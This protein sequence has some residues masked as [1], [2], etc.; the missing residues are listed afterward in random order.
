MRFSLILWFIL[1]I[2]WTPLHAEDVDVEHLAKPE[3]VDLAGCMWDSLAVVEKYRLDGK[4]FALWDIFDAACAAEMENVKSAAARQLKEEI[5]KQLLPDQLVLEMTKNA[6]E[7]YS[8]RPLSACKGTGCV[9]NTYRACLIGQMSIALKDRKSPIDFEKRSQQHCEDAENVARSALS[10]DFNEVQQRHIAGGLN[11]K[12]ND[13]IRNMLVGIRQQV[14]VLYGEDLTQTQP[15]RKS[16]KP[17]MCGATPCISLGEE[18][19]EY[20]CVIEQK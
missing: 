16:C 10:N 19:T 15:G 4:L 20:Q 18:P 8:K 5:Y 1:P 11:H 13:V 12:M 6:S 7:I 3:R 9:L 17:Q 2:L 14:V